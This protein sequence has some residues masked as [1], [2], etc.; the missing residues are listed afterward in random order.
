MGDY[1]PKFTMGFSSDI[2]YKSFRLYGLLDWRHGG[3]VV[4]VTQNVFDEDG[5]APDSAASAARLAAFHATGKRK[6]VYVQDASFLK[7]REVTLSYQLPDNVI[8]SLFAGNVTGVRLEV[9]GRNLATW[10]PYAGL[11]PEVSNFGN[12]NIN[13]G[14]DLAPYP[15]SRSYFFTLAVDF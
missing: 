10:S 11:D 1:E 15:P 9:S 3:D 6:S 8:R 2:T 7:L 4:N 14:Q 13:R 12:Q 5:I